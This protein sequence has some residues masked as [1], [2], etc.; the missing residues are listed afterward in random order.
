MTDQAILQLYEE[1]HTPQHVRRH[2]G[3]VATF[4]V[5]LGEKFIARGEPIDLELVRQ[6]SLLHDFVRIVD[7]RTLEPET[8]P[9]PFSKDDVSM[10][11]SLRAKYR[12]LHHAEAG[13]Q[14]LEE[15]GFPKLAKVVRKHAFIQIREGFDSWEEKIVYYADKRA[16]H[17][18][19]VSLQER[20]DDGRKRNVPESKDPKEMAR[21]DEG[22]FALEREI[23]SK[24]TKKL[25]Q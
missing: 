24:L 25:I 15:R 4:A 17:D 16:K 18:R 5:E 7:F 2:C 9:D 12:G 3:A 11:K 1:F 23:M 10:W 19:I 8:F 20:I 6:A 14:I 13:A 22:V 21:L